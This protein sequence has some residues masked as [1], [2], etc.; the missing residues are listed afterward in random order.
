[1][2]KMMPSK[3]IEQAEARQVCVMAVSESRPAPS[4]TGPASFLRSSLARMRFWI[5][6]SGHESGGEQQMPPLSA[7][8]V[9]LRRARRTAS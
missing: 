5:W 1:M 2:V 6:P 3:W 9:R 7:R 4:P 8:V